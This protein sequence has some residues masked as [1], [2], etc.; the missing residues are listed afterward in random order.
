LGKSIVAVQEN[1]HS[2]PAW[3]I[4]LIQ[5]FTNREM[6][7]ASVVQ[8]LNLE[9]DELASFLYGIAPILAKY[10][11]RL[12][13][14]IQALAGT[15]SKTSTYLPFEPASIESILLTGL[16]VRLIE[17][18]NRT[19]VLELHLARQQGNLAGETPEARFRSFI[20]QLKQPDIAWNTLKKYPVLSR[21]II[22]TLDQWVD[23]SLLFLQRLCA[24][25][26][27]I[28]TELSPGRAPGQLVRLESGMG[29]YHRN[30]QSV[31]IA[32]F[33][34]GFQVVYKPRSLA[35]EAHLQT[36]L[37]WL[38]EHGVK[39]S[40]RIFKVCDRNHYGWAEYIPATPCTTEAEV[41]RFYQRQGGYLALLYALKGA[42]FHAGNLIAAGEHPMLIDAE[43]L[44]QPTL[45]ASAMPASALTEQMNS[46]SILSIGLLPQHQTDKTISSLVEN[47]GLIGCA[48]QKSTRPMP[49]WRD[50]GT[51]TMRLIREY[52]TLDGDQNRPTLAGQ[53][54]KVEDYIE[55]IESGFTHVY[56]RLLNHQETLLGTD[57]PLHQLRSAETRIILRPTQLYARLL[58]ESFHPDLLEDALDRD[59]WLD[60]L[61]VGIAK[62]PILAQVLAAERDDLL[63]NDIP[64]FTTDL[65]SRDLRTSQ[66]HIIKDFF[67]QSGFS[68]VQNRLQKLTKADLNKQCQLIRVAL[69]NDST[70]PEII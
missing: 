58:W 48:G 51:D 17:M 63:R 55:A 43:T 40:F 54:V 2:S 36:W 65:H 28:C 15:A 29:D 8:T 27:L 9:K 64:I 13:Q 46:E 59:L 52:V 67:S 3:L 61:A 4:E 26:P 32:T 18:L 21:Q 16:P 1:C 68:C 38:N 50:Q 10:L 56:Q 57:S 42:D 35:L 39:P 66:G 5:A 33:S 60:N 62:A 11:T 25:W 49:Q 6:F 12:R 53:S 24:D 22:Q 41:H 23:N 19:M 44:F 69:Q 31:C 70:E 20:Q 7:P 37:C 34:S 47:S 30:G 45:E 14:K